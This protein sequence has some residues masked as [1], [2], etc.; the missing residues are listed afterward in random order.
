MDT[1]FVESDTVRGSVKLDWFSV[2]DIFDFREL[3]R[4]RGCINEYNIK[5]TYRAGYKYLTRQSTEY[6]KIYTVS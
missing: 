2:P 6:F 3:E 4:V 5:L 1:G